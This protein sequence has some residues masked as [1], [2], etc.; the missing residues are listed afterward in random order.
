[1]YKKKKTRYKEDNSFENEN[2]CRERRRKQT[3]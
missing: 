1:M 2:L 3:Y